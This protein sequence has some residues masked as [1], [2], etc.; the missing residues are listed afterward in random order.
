MGKCKDLLPSKI[1][2]VEVLLEEGYSIRNISNRC[3][4]S[5][6]SVHNIKKRKTEGTPHKNRSGRCGR[7]RSTTPH[8]D[9]LLLRNLRRTPHASSQQLRS[10]WNE[11]GVQASTTT[12]KRRLHELGCRS[13]IPRKVPVLTAEMKRKRLQFARN[14]VNWSV[15]DWKKV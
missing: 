3:Q 6:G 5:R 2:E 7:R 11:A 4:I 9:R 13:V 10:Q 15:D 1:R 12:V 8:D 14:H